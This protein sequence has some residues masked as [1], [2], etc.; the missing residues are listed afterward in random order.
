[1]LDICWNKSEKYTGTISSAESGKACE[2]WSEYY[3]E[4]DGHFPSNSAIN[5]SNYCRD[6]DKS[7]FLWCYTSS[8]WERCTSRCLKQT[9]KLF[10]IHIDIKLLI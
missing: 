9:G 3:D 4:G 6:P 2:A 7:G 10:Q 8:D 1:M 5:A